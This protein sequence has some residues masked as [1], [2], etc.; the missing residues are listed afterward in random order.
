MKSA[1][2]RIYSALPMICTI[3]LLLVFSSELGAQPPDYAWVKTHLGSGEDEAMGVATDASGNIYVAG[4]FVGNLS[5]G[6][7]SPYNNS[8]TNSDVFLAKYDNNGNLLWSKHVYGVKGE[9]HDIAVDG[10]GNCVIAGTFAGTLN[11]DSQTSMTATTGSYDLFVAKYNTNGNLLWA[12]QSVG[13]GGEIARGVAVDGY[14]NVIITGSIT[15]TVNFGTHPFFGQIGLT[16]TGLT[17]IY[18]AKYNTNGLILW[19]RQAIGHSGSSIYGTDL[20]LDV[21]V[22]NGRNI[23]VTGYLW[24]Y[25]RFGDVVITG[26]TNSGTNAFLVKYNEFG[27][28]LWAK[29]MGGAA[30]DIG[31]VVAVDASGNCIVAGSYRSLT[32]FKIENITFPHAGQEDIFIAKFTSGGSLVWA[33]HAGGVNPD[34][35]N[36]IVTD[37]SGNFYITGS[38]VQS[39]V[40]GQDPPVAGEHLIGEG[41]FDIF[42]AKYNGNGAVV[43]AKQTGGP[44]EDI[45]NGI[46]L[47]NNG[48]AVI[49]GK[50]EDDVRFDWM[51]RSSFDEGDVFVAKLNGF[52]LLTVTAVWWG[53]EVDV[54]ADGYVE[55]ATLYWRPVLLGSEQSVYYTIYW[56]DAQVAS[57]QGSTNASSR[58]LYSVVIDWSH[59]FRSQDVGVVGQME[60]DFKIRMGKNF[61]TSM[62]PF[63]EFGPGDFN[64]LNN[65]KMEVTAAPTT[66]SPTGLAALSGYSSAIPLA[67]AEPVT[68]AQTLLG[69]GAEQ[70]NLWGNPG[71]FSSTGFPVEIGMPVSRDVAGNTASPMSAGSSSMIRPNALTGYNVYKSTNPGGPYTRIASNLTSRYYRDEAVTNGTFYYYVVTAVYHEGESAYSAEASGRARAGGYTIYAGWAGSA[72]T[73]DGNIGA[74][75][76]S[77]AGTANAVYP[78]YG[79]TVTF[80][81]MNDNNY[82][83]LAVADQGDG[84]LADFDSFGILFDD[85]WNRT[86]P[87]SLNGQEG[88]IQL[89]RSSGSFVARFQD[90]YGTWPDNYGGGSWTTPSGVTYQISAASGHVQY[91]ARFDL[92]SSPLN[93]S[94]GD[95]IGILMYIWEA[96]IG[97]FSGLWPQETVNKLTAL[98]SGNGWAHGP[99]SYADVQLAGA[100]TVST[101]NTPSGPTSGQ[102]NQVYTYSTGGSVCNQG[103]WILYRFD[104]G[105]GSAPTAWSQQ[106]SMSHSWSSPGTYLVKVQASCGFAEQQGSPVT[107]DW[108]QTLTV[109][110]SSP[111]TVSTPNTP[112]GPSTGQTDQNYTY[113]TGGS[114]CSQG[115]GVL[116]RFDWGDGGA[117]TIWSQQTSMSHSWSS[118]GTYPVRAQASCGF[119]EQQGSPITSDWSQALTVTIS[120]PPSAGDVTLSINPASKTIKLT[121]TGTTDVV[122]TDATNFGLFQFTIDY[123]PSIVQVANNSDVVLGDFLGS[124]GRTAFSVGLDIDNSSGR[125]SYSALSAGEGAGP[126]GSGVLATITWTPQAEGTSALDLRDEQAGTTD[127]V[128]FTTTA[129]DGEIVVETRFW[130]DIDGDGDVDIFDIQ[131]VAAHW[132]TQE[133]DPG[134]DPQ[135]DFD[136]DG[137]IDIFDVMAVALWWNKELPSMTAL[138]TGQ[139]A[140]QMPGQAI[141]FRRAEER[142]LEV[143]EVFVENAAGLAGFEVELAATGQLPEIR[144]IELGK[145]FKET[146]RGVLI[147]GPEIAGHGSRVKFG[148]ISYGDGNGIAGSGVLARIVFPEEIEP[149]SIDAVQCVDDAGRLLDGFSIENDFEQGALTVL[150]ARYDLLQ[151]SPNPF[152][153]E[154][155]IR[156]ALPEAC[157]A[158]LRIYDLRGKEIETLVKGN[159][160]AGEYEVVWNAAGIPSG[161]YLYRL[162]AGS[163]VLTKKLILQK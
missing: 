41:N 106:T 113:S 88:I 5:M 118:P 74:G 12:R 23:Y 10:S 33:K 43:W 123:D 9:V 14:G 75:E 1:Y 91:E 57:W 161:V 133:G 4:N 84:T 19:A 156:F 21:A 6:Q 150:P 154:T 77:T 127:N 144:S 45:S 27:T 96:S 47:D 157:H 110:I 82:L 8:D 155:K 60:M 112:S 116:Y 142:G 141:R 16:S 40:F 115:H 126:D 50:Y 79:G 117:P 140:K 119:A 35:V 145:A 130:A 65:Y 122:V 26:E 101:P 25:G 148:V 22:D 85:D 158:V 70:E 99:F 63:W 125:L 66:P 49:T 114:A 153:S 67:W 17:D 163:H 128:P 36:G 151:N 30:T 2:E 31:R 54:D 138:R 72:P 95:V 28:A 53:N 139:A 55:S 42:I 104:W 89:Y 97:G 39:A 68:G 38:F 103:H 59:A 143:M 86:W 62:T 102:T 98:T 149:I 147:L 24:R 81:V 136:D 58:D 94:P 162:E 129:V 132:N 15:G 61:M 121:E 108:S 64:A 13:S 29:L 152:N 87:P 51:Y 69:K 37:P 32:T 56:K 90:F 73:I 71:T 135:Y 124:T 107:S 146:G 100:H 111:H 11:F 46:A 159:R 48:D 76:W 93:P 83:Y 3:L 131:T 160:Q 20:G 18:V 92:T 120:S 78:G 34:F 7:G 105:D 52:P 80:Y 109:T 137:D 134:Y 44:E